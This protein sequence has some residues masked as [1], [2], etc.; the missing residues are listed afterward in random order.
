MSQTYTTAPLYNVQPCTFVFTSGTDEGIQVTIADSKGNSS[1]CG[2]AFIEVR[3][4][5][6]F[7]SEVIFGIEE[8]L[9]VVLCSM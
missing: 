7:L 5:K 1:F 9:N 2:Q 6:E 8:K 3:T 4:G